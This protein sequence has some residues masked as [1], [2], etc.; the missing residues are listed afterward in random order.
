M[1]SN[2]ISY[3]EKIDHL[4]FFAAF[5]V[6]MFHTEWF[7]T[8]RLTSWIP[9]FHEG[10]AGV[11]LFMVISGLILTMIAHNREINVLKFYWNRILR[12]YP[13]YILVVSLGYFVS[14]ERPTSSG[15]DYLLAL[16]PISNMYRNAY[17][18]FGGTLWSVAVELQFYLLFPFLIAG[19]QRYGERFAYLL[20]AMML[21]LRAAIF[22]HTG[23]AHHFAY[24]TIF[25]AVDSF[26]MGILSAR[27]YLKREPKISAW[28]P[29]L[30]LVA[31]NLVISIIFNS[32]FF[33][34]D[35]VMGRASSLSRIWIVWPTIAALLFS[36]LTVT[37]LQSSHRL[38]FSAVIANF[39]K[40]S[41]STYVWHWMVILFVF[42]AV[43]GYGLHPYFVGAAIVFPLTIA[44]SALSYYV[45]ERPFLDMRV[46]YAN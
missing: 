22:I 6:L 13:L 11:Q 2:N 38:P 45:I 3:N 16:L 20:I 25:G 8:I 32:N 15:V 26:V 7:S 24:F 35:Y 39:G 42:K 5:T 28:I 34:V 43:G 31:I 19:I 40:W 37:Y 44:W 30:V 36:V 1:N 14:V 33:H 46:K 12:I 17:G 9:I 27:F 29:V 18:A 21:A 23:A 41:Y 4:R 10:H